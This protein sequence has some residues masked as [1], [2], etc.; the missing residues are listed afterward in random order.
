MLDEIIAHFFD[1]EIAPGVV[2]SLIIMIFICIFSFVV[3]AKFKNANPIEERPGKFVCVIATAV[4]TVQK[5]TIDIMGKKWKNFAGYALTLFIYVFLAFTFS[6]I[7]IPTL[8][9]LPSPMTYIAVPLSLGLCTF[10]L[11][12][13]TAIKANKWKYFTRYTDP[14]PPYIPAFIPINLL[15]MWSPLLSMS[16][17]LFGNAISGFVLMSLVYTALE[18]LSSTIFSFITI[19]E[20]NSVFLAPFITPILHAYFDLFSGAIQTLVFTML[21]M[22]NISQEDPDDSEE[23]LLEIQNAN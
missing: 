17:R 8:F 7:G 6:V 5:F 15:S 23:E 21:T 4:E 16:L 12:H 2:A 14:L 18:S 13:I 20:L 1:F 10:I 3:Y 19:G 11:I 22:I 9:G